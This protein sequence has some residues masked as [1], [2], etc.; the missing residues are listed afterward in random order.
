MTSDARLVIS[1]TVG[2]SRPN[3]QPTRA[4]LLTLF[5]RTAACAGDKSRRSPVNQARTLP[6]PEVALM[7]ADRQ[8]CVTINNVQLVG[9]ST[10][11]AGWLGL[12]NVRYLRNKATMVTGRDRF[13]GRKRVTEACVHLHT[14]LFII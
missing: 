7:A 13:K 4:D 8:K 3:Y 5:T 9:S 10:F 12:L 6:L 1:W 11:A 2:Y 14:I